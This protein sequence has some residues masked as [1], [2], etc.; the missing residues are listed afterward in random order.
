MV[1]ERAKTLTIQRVYR[2]YKGR[3]RVRRL[4]LVEKQ[5]RGALALQC[6]WRRYVATIRVNDWRVNRFRHRAATVIQAKARMR[7]ACKR[8]ALLRVR[9]AAAITLQYAWL[10][11]LARKEKKHRKQ[12]LCAL[13]MQRIV[14]GRLGRKR[15]AFFDRIRHNR[16]EMERKALQTIRWLVVGH[17]TRRKFGPVLKEYIARRHYHAIRIQQLLQGFVLAA[18]ARARVAHLRAMVKAE[19]EKKRAEYKR[20]LKLNRSA[21]TIQRVQRGHAARKRV[22]RLKEEARLELIRRTHRT[23]MYYRLKEQYLREVTMFTRAAVVRIQCMFRCTKARLVVR[24][25]KRELAALAI[26]EYWRGYMLTKAAVRVLTEQRLLCL[27]RDKGAV[28]AQ[29]LV[30]GFLARLHCERHRRVREIKW[31]LSAWRKRVITK[32]ALE[33]FR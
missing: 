18:K 30:R 28:T 25:R 19:K 20:A 7:S 1:L 31:F 23:P 27:R 8:V 4:R 29:R 6:L 17:L 11:Y 13:A 2:G 3:D 12:Q 22:L 24:E 15:F 26:Q 9:I 10:C 16:R 33:S 21:V 32:D 5:R 14:R